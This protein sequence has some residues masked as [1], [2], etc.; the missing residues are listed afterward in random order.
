MFWPRIHTL[1]IM[2]AMMAK[3]ARESGSHARVGVTVGDAP[4]GVEGHQDEGYEE[5]IPDVPQFQHHIQI[6]AVALRH[7]ADPTWIINDARPVWA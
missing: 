7:C 3:R 1:S 5:R 4:N 2:S 6:A